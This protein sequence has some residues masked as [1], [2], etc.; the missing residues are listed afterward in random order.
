MKIV[1]IVGK[2]YNEDELE[3][4]SKTIRKWYVIKQLKKEEIA[5]KYHEIQNVEEIK[6]TYEKLM[7]GVDE[8]TRKFYQEY[9]KEN[10]KETYPIMKNVSSY[11]KIR[12]DDGIEF[13]LLI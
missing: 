3:E 11:A 2:S 4:N 7:T 1:K 8:A 10:W 6:R 5:G 12:P 13:C 9:I